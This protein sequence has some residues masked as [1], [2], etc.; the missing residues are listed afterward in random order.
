MGGYFDGKGRQ[1]AAFMTPRISSFTD[2]LSSYAPDL[3]PGYRGLG[4]G[5]M[6]DVAGL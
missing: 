1:P 2:F 4:G 6:P 5:S 3:L